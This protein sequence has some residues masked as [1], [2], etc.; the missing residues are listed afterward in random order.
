M[1]EVRT[2]CIHMM[3]AWDWETIGKEKIH[4]LVIPYIIKC[5]CTRK[6]QR[7]T[8]ELWGEVHFDDE[9]VDNYTFPENT[10]DDKD[11]EKMAGLGALFG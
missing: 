3:E 4:K 11:D 5:T 7:R 6:W 10:T 9:P 2:C 8:E 1:N